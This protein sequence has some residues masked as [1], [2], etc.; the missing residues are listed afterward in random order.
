MEHTKANFR[1]LREMV[2][3][4][5]AHLARDLGIDSRSVRRWENPD[6]TGYS[7][8]EGAWRILKDARFEQLRTVNAFLDEIEAKED[9]GSAPGKVFI[10]YWASA[11]E[12]ARAHPEADPACWQMSN[13]TAR[14]IAHELE[15]MGYEVE[16][17]WPGLKAAQEEADLTEVA[18]DQSFTVFE[19]ED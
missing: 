13:A 16:F 12:Y 6:A 19:G 10:T 11:T 14:L 2:G 9:Q 17:G 15:Q 5:Q 8:R 4:S 1:A 3:I 7:P 18:D